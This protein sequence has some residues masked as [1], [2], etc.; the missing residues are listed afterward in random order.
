MKNKVEFN[1][2]GKK[3]LAIFAHADDADY[4]CGGTFLKWLKMGAKGSIVIVTNGDKGTHDQS[5]TPIE[6]A[7]LRRE[8]QLAAS[9]FLG[10][11]NT[12]FLDYPDAHLE[13][14]QGLKKNLVK[15]IRE[16][17]PDVVFTWDP[18]MVYSLKRSMVNHPDHRA[19]GQ[20]T[21]DAIFPMARD[22]LTF[23]ELR[24]AGLTTHE[25]RDIFLY[26]FDKQDFFVD[27]TAELA[28]KLKLLSFHKSQINMNEAE[29]RVRNWNSENGKNIGADF[30]EGFVHINI[31]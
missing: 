17:K 23:G 27:I 21:L 12:W 6:L 14:D 22:F 25:V 16:Y 1:P 19:V 4:G 31:G 10:L 11:E 3:L 30:A 24:E 2:K 18:T 8:E 26:N 5:L 7:T 9:K 29:K 28:D 13:I 15:I 20:A